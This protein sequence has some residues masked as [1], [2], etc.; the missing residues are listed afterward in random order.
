MKVTFKYYAQIR[1]RA[2]TETETVELKDGVAALEALRSLRHGPEFQGL[3]FDGQGN[4]QPTILIVVNGIP[5]N[6]EQ[7]LKDG[8]ELSLFSPVAGG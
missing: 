8:D 6:A 7:K 3:L 4:L 5:A 2:G 1:Q